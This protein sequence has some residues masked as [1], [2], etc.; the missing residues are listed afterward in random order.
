MKR[1]LF[2]AQAGLA[3]TALGLGAPAQ[4]AASGPSVVIGWNRVL[5]SSIAATASGPTVAARALSMVHEAI[6]NAWSAYDWRAGFSLA[7]LANRPWWE[8]YNSVKAIA[9][10]HAARGVLLNLFPTQAASIE[11]AMADLINGLPTAHPFGLTAA[12]LGQQ[13]AQALLNARLNDGSNQLG[14]LASGAYADT[15]GYVPVNGPDSLVDPNRWQ[16]LRVTNA[17]GV[18]SVQKFLTPHW[19]QVRPF[20]LSSGSVYRPALG[21]PAPTRDEMDQL[22]Q[23][24]AELTDRRKVI[25]DFWANNPGSVTP[26]G[27]W[28]RFAE[29]VSEQDGNSLNRDVKLFFAIAQAAL[30]ASI[31][32][33]DAKRTYDS[34]RPISA[35]RHHFR[36]Q[37]IRSWAGP[38][39]GTAWIRGEDWRPYQR[40][41]SP[42]P[43]F[44]EFVSGHSTFSAA[45]ATVMAGIRGDAVTLSFTFP[46]NGVPFD[47]TVPAAPVTLAWTK[48]SDAAASAGQSRRLGGIHFVRGDYRGRTLG[49]QVGLAVLQR[50][51]RLF[52][53]DGY[54][55]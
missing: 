20:A 14:N 46:A 15:S 4:A 34:V 18:T 8:A 16:P 6:Y 27:Q 49:R 3:T 47:P 9:I 42:T 13:A 41:T 53:D 38:G 24:S 21:D 48:L 12:Q 45:M 17:A 51:A 32:S 19:G 22:I 7:G 37:M 10:C 35:I 5:T 54:C 43:P 40:P 28:T 44:P 26:P 23:M 39:L 2:L 55:D 1:R 50:C 36:G 25:V 29:I 31:A 33:W 52:N 30:D 11:A